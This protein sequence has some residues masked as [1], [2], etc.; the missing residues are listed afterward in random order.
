MLSNY[1]KIAV[2]NLLKQKFYSAINIMGLA[3]GIASCLLIMVYIQDELSYDRFH[4]KADRIYRL[5]EFI[6]TEGSGERSS[7][8]P[9]PV[10]PTL[11]DEYPSYVD[12]Y[13]RLF[14]F[15]APSLSLGNLENDKQFNESRIFFVDS[16]F[17]DVFDYELLQG[18]KFSA[19]REVNSLV[20]TESMAQKY[21]DNA[22]PIGKSLR[23]QGTQDLEVT[24]V[25]PDAPLNSH[26]Q[27]D[28]LVSFSS[29]RQHYEGHLPETW[30]WNP[31]WT[32]IV[33]NESRTPIDLEE[34]LPEFV[35]K[36][37]PEIIRN[38]TRVALQPL[39]D[40][41][42]KSDLDFEIQANSSEDNVYVFA[43]IGGFIL[44]IAAINFMNLSTARSI[45]RAREVGL[46]KTIGGQRSQL[47]TQ[48]LSESVVT[49]IIALLVSFI[50]VSLTLPYFNA[51][52][53]KS[54][55]MDVLLTES[56]LVGVIVI[57]IA[58][59]IGSGLYPAFVLSS[60]S[61]KRALES[62]RSR[63]KGLNI[64]RVLVILQFTISIFLIVATVIAIQQLDH[65]RKSDNGFDS[66]QVLFVPVLKTSMGMQYKIF[67]DEVSRDPRVLQVT[68]L[69]EVLGAKHQG[70]NYQ[71]EGMEESK[72]FSRLNIRHDFFKTFGIDIAAGRAYSEDIKSDVFEALVVNEALVRQMGWT[73]EE[74][75]GKKYR[76]GNREGTIIGV[77]RDFN[78]TSKH[79][80]IGPLV[81]HLN[82][83]PF[84]FELFIK[85]MA[86]RVDMTDLPATIS[87]INENWK[88]LVP[89]RPFQYFF[90]DDELNKLYKAEEKLSRV[91]GIFSFLA[92]VVACLGLFGLASFMT[93][94]RSKEIGI[95]KVM[96][97][98]IG[99]IV[100]L[101]S[102]GFSLLVAISITLAIPISWLVLE[103]WLQ[104]FAYRID[105]NWIVFPVVGMATLLIALA[106]I[107]FQAFKAASISPAK[108]LK[109]E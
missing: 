82:T 104:G 62:E 101:L 55:T 42:L 38:D 75:V 69:E 84:A 11:L 52:A 88:A 36:Y 19:L 14:D 59:G 18:D 64:R 77:S 10:G 105:I 73:N 54:V 109:Q 9:F 61:P 94:Q 72:L 24:G 34:L 86:L 4:T 57:V 71:F 12:N 102:G 40:I 67:K 91:A 48:F 20:I 37:F 53:E 95:R 43:I 76:F 97:G 89:E 100:A 90:L 80:R 50:L 83:N 93:E 78:F 7:S 49:T 23:F 99:Q 35:Q 31:C 16:T 56:V 60:F 87:S 21:F 27:F 26:W 30:Y 45:K 5:N 6:E 98:S 15:Q 8:M 96:G 92:I 46:R 2:R 85:Y 29:L 13:V 74:A 1:L 51:L 25:M 68:A 41:H 17:F 106:T 66:E 28:F 32:Y 108:S 103:A 33:L 22:D 39:T 107:S 79:N 81:L 58:I 47:I 3:V 63:G 70:A 65:L 44:L